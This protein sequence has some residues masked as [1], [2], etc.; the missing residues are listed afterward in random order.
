MRSI[1]HFIKNP[2]DLVEG[3]LKKTASFWPD[4]AYLRIFYY[5]RFG[6]PLNLKNPK[7]FTEKLNWLKINCKHPEYTNY[8]DKYEV[9]KFVESRLGSTEYIIKT[10]GVW[11]SFDEIDFSK[12]PDKFVLKTTNG[13]GNNSVVIC[14]D[15]LNLDKEEAREKL[16]LKDSKKSFISYREYPYYDVKPRIIAEEYIEAPNNEL[17]DYKIFCFNGKPKFLFVGTE[18]QKK[19]VDVKFDFYDL[20]F[21][22]L[23]LKN[24]HENSKC[25]ITKPKKFEMMLDIASELSEGIPN[26]RIDLYNLNGKIY[27]GEMTFFHFSGFVPFEPDEW[28]YKFGELLQLPNRHDMGGVNYC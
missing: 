14:R 28:D 6:R 23:P 10:L 24:G 21:N 11:D 13:G 12:L 22:H 27:F 26:V 2:K 7:A 3:V 5:I 9:K 18:R 4:A 16:K 20:E 17:S 19:G 15:K 8:V 1:T 25:N